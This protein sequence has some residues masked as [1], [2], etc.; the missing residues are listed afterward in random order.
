MEGFS[1]RGEVL[2]WYEHF[3]R[4][5]LPWQIKPNAYR[6]WLSEI[7]LQQTQVATVIPYFERFTQRFSTVNHLAAANLDEVLHLWTGLGYY[8]RARNLHRT[9][10]IIAED[11]QGEFPQ[12]LSQLMA[13]PGIG[14]ST[15]GAILSLA[16]AKPAAILDGNVKRLL[17]RF[18]GIAGW[19]GESRVAEQL[20]QL[21]ESHVRDNKPREFTQALMDMGALICTRTQPKCEQCPLQQQCVAN[22]TQAIADYP[23]K[24][25]QKIKPTRHS[26]F[27]ILQSQDEILLQQRPSLGLWGGLWCFPEYQ[28]P[29]TIIDYCQQR[30]SVKIHQHNIL[31]KFTHTFSHFHLQI[32]PHHFTVTKKINKVQ[33]FD[34]EKWY[35][36]NALPAIGLAKPIKQLIENIKHPEVL[37]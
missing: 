6:V 34:E 17:A 23:G 35:Y 14:R 4:K 19:P 1:F 26:H 28:E 8:A 13:L 33:E 10:N 16:F 12:E 2:N 5:E 11:Y 3:G 29:D 15:A 22:L 25:I 7:M 9:A 21:A 24:K 27:I 36:M 18:H 31:P 20:W 32:I 37:T 30:F